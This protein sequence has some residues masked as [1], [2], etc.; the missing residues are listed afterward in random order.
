MITPLRFI[1][2]NHPQ[3]QHFT[4]GFIQIISP[5]LNINHITFNPRYRPAQTALKPRENKFP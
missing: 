1:Y 2:F 3:I 5:K 4:Y